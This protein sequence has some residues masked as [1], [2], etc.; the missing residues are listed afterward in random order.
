VC[1]PFL[2]QAGLTEADLRQLNPDT[3]WNYEVGG[4]AKVGRM[5]VTGAVFQMDWKNIQQSVIL[6]QCQVP[7]AVNVGAARSRGVELE[8]AG[9]PF[10]GFDVRLGFGYNDA[11]ITDEG[12]LHARPVGSRLFNVPK[13]TVSAAGDYS[14]AISGSSEAFVGAD[15]SFIDSSLSGV[16][17][18][19]RP[20][21]QIVNARLGIRRDKLEIGLYARNLL[22][23]RANLGDLSNLSFGKFDDGGNIIPRAVILQPRQLGVSFRYGF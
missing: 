2:A 20:S 4:K 23:A 22:D 17:E 11:K 3:V 12:T 21:Y 9:Q 13:F 7:R 14:W 6:P 18:Q 5:T 10:P 1:V 16:V 8:L 19:V 15:Y